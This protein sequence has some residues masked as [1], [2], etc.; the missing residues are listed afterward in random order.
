MDEG[1]WSAGVR[2]GE[3]TYFDPAGSVTRTKHYRSA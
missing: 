2:V 3:W 1:R